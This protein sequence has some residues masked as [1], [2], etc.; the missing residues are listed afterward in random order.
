[1]LITLLMALI[2]NLIMMLDQLTVAYHADLFDLDYQS[3]D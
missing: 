3:F 1:M 2:N